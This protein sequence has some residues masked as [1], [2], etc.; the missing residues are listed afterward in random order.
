MS[1]KILLTGASGWFGKSFISEY[2]DAFGLKNLKNLILVTSDGRSISH[3]RLPTP[4]KTMSMDDAKNQ[5]Y[6]DVIVQSAFLTRDKIERYGEQ[7]YSLKSESL[8][9]NFRFILKNNTNAE[10]NLISSG[11]IYKDKSLYG[12]YKRLEENIATA[13]CQK[14]LNIFRIFM[15]T[16]RFIDYRDWSAICYFLKQRKNKNDIFIN[17]SHNHCRSIV[18]FEDVARFIILSME[19]AVQPKQ[20]LTV[21]DAVADNVTII[22]LARCISSN[23]VRV[24]LPINFNYNYTDYEYASRSTSFIEQSLKMGLKLKDHKLQIKNIINSTYFESF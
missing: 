24:N 15:A 20:N 17:S 10:V 14:T 13:H 21:Y 7:E 11:A 19:N 3:P 1:K 8:L 2:I 23:L 4:L 12:E 22:E 6:L 9:E 18:C 16:T 5:K